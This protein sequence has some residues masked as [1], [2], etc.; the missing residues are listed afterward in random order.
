MNHGLLVI[1]KPPGMTSRD[2]VDR[3]M[4]WFPKGT[5]IGHTGTLDPLATG[6]LVLCVGVATRLAE[7]VQA[8]KKTYRAG[9]FLGARSDTDDADGTIT[10]VA[11][12]SAPSQSSLVA[13]LAELTGPQ[14]QI[15]PAFSAAKVS[16]RRAYK[17]ARQGKNPDL[18]PR[19]VHVYRLQLLDYRFP[20]VE[21]E[22][23]CSKGTYIR[24]LA[25]DLG[26]KL[27]C[28]GYVT[29][30]RRTRIGPFTVEQAVSLHEPVVELRPLANAVQE[31][32]RCI[33]DAEAVSRL[34]DGQG[35]PLQEVA[36]EKAPTAEADHAAFDIS[37][38]LL[39]V[40]KLE[41]ETWRPIK[42]I[43]P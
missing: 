19:S 15:P 39:A 20:N 11:N 33:V 35:L 8:M 31:L 7:Y 36:T 24:S 28:G 29:S 6:V 37:G 17:L 25:R 32:P 12:A 40:L 43:K 1:D 3:A 26:E 30:L 14:E 4:R 5:R 41:N 22:I 23:E 34:R 2:A 21:L 38:N 16:G 18:Q 10:P 13:A 42:V 9:I 27:G